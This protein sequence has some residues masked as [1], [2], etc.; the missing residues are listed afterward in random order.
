MY[1]LTVYGHCK[2]GPFWNQS[3]HIQLC[4][5]PARC[6]TAM[7]FKLLTQDKSGSDPEFL[8]A[9]TLLDIINHSSP[10]SGQRALG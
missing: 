1:N 8:P 10:E 2:N 9:V 7:E 3:E 5:L 4:T 6:Q